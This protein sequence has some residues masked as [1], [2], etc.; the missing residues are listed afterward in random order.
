[1]AAADPSGAG[2]GKTYLASIDAAADGS[3][4]ATFAPQ[5]SCKR[6]TTT[7]TDAMGNTS[8]FSL[9]RLVGICVYL[10]PLIAMIVIFAGGAGGSAFLVVI[11][12]RPPDLSS[13]PLAALGG[14]LGVGLG[15]LFLALPQVHVGEGEE[16]QG[17]QPPGQAPPP[18]QAPPTTAVP[19]APATI[20]PSPTVTM[21]PT[22]EPPTLTLTPTWTPT[23]TL[24]PAAAVARQNAHCRFGP[25]TMYEDVGFLLEG[26][27]ALI[28]GRNGERTWWYVELPDGRHCWIAASVVD[29][30]GDLEPLPVV[31][32]PPSPTPTDTPESG[33]L[34]FNPNLQKNLCV[35]PCPDGAQPGDPCEP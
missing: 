2:E 27:Q 5:D 28:L 14:I 18:A 21:T 1:V 20:S 11:R 10:P 24:G 3:F 8:V 12:R 15:L 13:L 30:L 9:N 17:Q 35:V 7:A 26:E 23:P 22:P 6:L 32:P 33:C 4:T 19:I 25:G 34:V 31:K 16:D 29:A